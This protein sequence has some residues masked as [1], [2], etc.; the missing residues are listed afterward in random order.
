LEVACSVLDLVTD[1]IRNNIQQRGLE[2]VQKLKSLSTEIPDAITDVK[3][4]GLLFACE[5]NPKRYQAVGPRSTETYLRHQGIGVIHGG[6]NALRFTP[7]FAI[8][9][10]EV[11][12]IIDHVR[13]AL[14]N[15]PK[16]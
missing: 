15:G 7:H 3:G 9:S 13:E 4:T 16:I 2:F 1:G 12:M 6:K 14:L 10:Q 8:S 11:D 5:L